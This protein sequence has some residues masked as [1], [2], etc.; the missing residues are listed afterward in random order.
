MWLTVM[1]NIKRKEVERCSPFLFGNFVS[2]EAGV[3]NFDDVAL[4]SVRRWHKFCSYIYNLN[5]RRLYHN[6]R[7]PNNYQGLLTLDQISF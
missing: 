7:G 1:Q 4:G 6:Y 2:E 5:L 3:L